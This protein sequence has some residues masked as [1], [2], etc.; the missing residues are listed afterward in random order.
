MN[1]KYLRVL[2]ADHGVPCS[3]H[4]DR[5]ERGTGNVT[6]RCH[7]RYGSE[8]PHNQSAA[9]STDCGAT[10][11]ANASDRVTASNLRADLDRSRGRHHSSAVLGGSVVGGRRFQGMNP[12]ATIVRPTG[13]IATKGV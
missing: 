8:V 10:A 5:A 3:W 12:L 7:S 1:C 13:G 6:A 9:S 11:L 2:H 4:A